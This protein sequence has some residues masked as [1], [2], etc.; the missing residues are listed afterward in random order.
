MKHFHL[1]C[2]VFTLVCEMVCACASVYAEG[3]GRASAD[4]QSAIDTDR[5]AALMAGLESYERSIRS[6]EWKHKTYHPPATH[7]QRDTWILVED[8]RFAVDEAWRWRYLSVIHGFME[9]EENDGV[10]WVSPERRAFGQAG[11]FIGSASHVDRP[12]VITSSRNSTFMGFGMLDALGRKMEH[13]EDTSDPNFSVHAKTIFEILSEC[14]S[15]AYVAPADIE[16]WPGIRG[17]DALGAAFVIRV[18]PVR[19]YVPR[20]ITN[21]HPVI[22]GYFGVKVVNIEVQRVDD[23]Y[24][25]KVSLLANPARAVLDEKGT[26]PASRTKD[27]ELAPQLQGL[28]PICV[29]PEVQSFVQTHTQVSR[30]VMPD[31][32]Q[33]WTGPLNF[34]EA[35]GF[36][37]APLIVVFED[38]VLNKPW[39]S[40]HDMVSTF[41]PSREFLNDMKRGQQDRSAAMEFLESVW[42]GSDHGG[43]P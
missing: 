1:H 41:E 10:T 32:P 43:K 7:L 12:G 38:I 3:S 26:I 11:I 14:V 15:L 21:P 4:T 28:P 20:V 17:I 33:V 34:D 42:A 23:V 16:P 37:C 25:P 2:L 39:P 18:D 22:P 35:D 6:I 13:G 5:V 30:S 36:L 27:L 29:T 8:S 9:N 19:G 24:V 40:V 31:E